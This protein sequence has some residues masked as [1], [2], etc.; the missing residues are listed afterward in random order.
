[1]HLASWMAV[2]HSTPLAHSAVA[3]VQLH[4]STLLQP[5]AA[6]PVRT[7]RMSMAAIASS[8]S[9][10]GLAVDFQQ[11][12]ATAA[13]L[14]AAA[15]PSARSSWIRHL[16]Y[17]GYVLAFVAVSYSVFP[18]LFFL[19]LSM[20]AAWVVYWVTQLVRGAAR[21]LTNRCR[22]LNM[23]MAELFADDYYEA[24]QSGNAP[25]PECPAMAQMRVQTQQAI[26]EE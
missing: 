4:R 24:I 13:A 26:D 10:P 12:A 15:S 2:A 17:P 7:R 14:S 18:I 8:E 19:N 22:G 11:A 9:E 25:P 6:A 20:Y 21:A 5:A 1:M 16:R 3:S 23:D